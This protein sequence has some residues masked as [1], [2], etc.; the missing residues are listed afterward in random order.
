MA[1]CKV[2]SFWARQFL[3]APTLA[4]FCKHPSPQRAENLGLSQRS[5]HQWRVI[6]ICSNDWSVHK[7]CIF[8]FWSWNQATL[9]TACLCFTS[10]WTNHK[11]MPVSGHTHLVSGKP[12]CHHERE[13]LSLKVVWSFLILKIYC[14]Y[15]ILVGYCT[16][17]Y[18]SRS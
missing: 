3:S 13:W 15:R 11:V 5:I 6:V 12:F 14:K 1:L 4:E 2:L 7:Q 16:R 10:F 18:A 9:A 8:E 17:C